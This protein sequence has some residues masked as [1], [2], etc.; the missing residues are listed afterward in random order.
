MRYNTALPCWWYTACG[1]WYAIAFA[2]DKK[3]LVPKN[4]SFLAPQTGLEPVTPRLTAACSTDWAIKANIKLSNKVLSVSP[5]TPTLV[6]SGRCFTTVHTNRRLRQPL[7]RFIVPRTRSQALQLTAACSTDISFKANIK[8][9]NI[10]FTYNIVYCKQFVNMQ[11]LIL[12]ICVCRLKDIL[13]SANFCVGIYLSFRDAAVQVL[14][15]QVSLTS[16]FG[17][18]TG[19][20]SP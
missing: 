1:W 18:G 19:G 7:L 17:M 13:K 3:T 12:Q 6:V 15:A 8:L 2:M 11:T 10:K 16:V 9:S 5:V 20:P 14:S 4:E